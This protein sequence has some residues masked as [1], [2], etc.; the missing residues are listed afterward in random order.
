MRFKKVSGGKTTYYVYQGNNPLM[1]YSPDDGKYTYYIYAGNTL[2]A[3]EKDGAKK[4][5]H[6]DHLGS[7]RLVTDDSG[8]VVARYKFKPYGEQESYIVRSISLRE[9]RPMKI[10]D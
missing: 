6:H 10:L 3:E 9:N 4:F 1:E 8:T 2:I 7:T 5:Y